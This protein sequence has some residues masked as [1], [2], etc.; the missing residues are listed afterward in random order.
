MN[1]F[2]YIIFLTS[3]WLPLIY[4]LVNSVLTFSKYNIEIYCINFNH[5]F[6]NDRIKCKDINISTINF[7]NICKCKL[8]ASI[9]TE[10]DIALI[11]DGDM[12]VTNNIDAIFTE[13]KERLITSEYPLFAKHPHNHF[14]AFKHLKLFTNKEPKMKWVYANYIFS[15]SHKLFLQKVL[16]IMNNLSV[17]YHYSISDEDIFN[18]VL[19]EYEVDYDLG[20][21]YFPNGFRCV[22]EYYLTGENK[23][24]ENHILENY[25]NFNTPIKMYAFHG[26]EIK[27]INF[28]KYIV[29]EICKKFSIT[30]VNFHL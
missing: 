20:Y 16:D 14:N 12:I 29:D 28:G 21:N 4:N 6:N 25:T 3:D 18:S 24:G 15:K 11:L 9:A 1:N 27:N 2:G 5:D 30:N 17:E 10:F 22:V 23:D 26:H 19:A 7:Y 13:N 8:I